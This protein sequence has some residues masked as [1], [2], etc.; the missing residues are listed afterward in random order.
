MGLP[1]VHNEQCVDIKDHE[2]LC[3]IGKVYSQIEFSIIKGSDSYVE[4]TSPSPNSEVSALNNSIY[5]KAHRI[6]S[7][8]IALLLFVR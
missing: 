6:N 4:L 2:H 8:N 3:D 5:W 7:F 1:I